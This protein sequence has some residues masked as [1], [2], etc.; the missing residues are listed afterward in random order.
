MHDP[1]PERAAR[2]DRP[3]ALAELGIADLLPG[4]RLDEHRFAPQGYSMNALGPDGTYA[5]LH[6][7][8]ESPGS[9]VSFDTDQPL[10]PGVAERW[11]SALVELF[12]PS[13]VDVLAFHPTRTIAVSH[14]GLRRAHGVASTGRLR[15]RLL[16]LV[17]RQAG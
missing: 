7:T 12:A 15:R 16:P 6:V 3:G 1:Q 11:V 10:L 13:A 14:P 5:T 8:P 9:Y 4:Y 2:F 17:R